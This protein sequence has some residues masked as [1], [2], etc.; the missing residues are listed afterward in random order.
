MDEDGDG[1]QTG[2]AAPSPTTR[3]PSEADD[4]TS[5]DE[6]GLW[7]GTESDTAGEEA[8]PKRSSGQ[9]QLQANEEETI[10]RS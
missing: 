3:C 2:T 7:S 1:S 5:D 8:I 6:E 4:D 10:S 9:L